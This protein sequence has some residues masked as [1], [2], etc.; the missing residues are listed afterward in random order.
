MAEIW[1]WLDLCR[2]LSPYLGKAVRFVSPLRLVIYFLAQV[3][4]RLHTTVE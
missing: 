3:S 1:L 4:D 2:E